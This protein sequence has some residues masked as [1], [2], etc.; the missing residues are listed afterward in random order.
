ML[1]YGVNEALPLIAKI[2]T[3]FARVANQEHLYLIGKRRHYFFQYASP[4]VRFNF[5]GTSWSKNMIV[6]VGKDS[7]L[8]RLGNLSG[9]GYAAQIG[10]GDSSTNPASGDTDLN[11]AVNK[12]WQTIISPDG[13]TYV[14]PTLFLYVSIGYSN[15]NF[16]WNEFGLRDQNNVMWAHALD[17]SFTGGGG[18]P[19][20]KTGSQAAIAE[21]QL[22]L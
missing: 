22:S 19:L 17:P 21:W 18:A 9:G 6:D 8:K 12:Y 7:I 15:G 13:Y 1:R 11:A 20:T 10:I 3:L 2:M 14:R 5:V 16:T 4:G